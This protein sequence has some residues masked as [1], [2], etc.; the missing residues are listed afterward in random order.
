MIDP[1]MWVAYFRIH[2][3]KVFALFFQ[4]PTLPSLASVLEILLHLAKLLDT[5]PAREQ[6]L[7]SICVCQCNTERD[8]G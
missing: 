3:P 1:S 8:Q 6:A 4:P 2:H 5:P 7:V